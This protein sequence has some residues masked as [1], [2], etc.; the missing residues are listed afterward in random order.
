QSYLDGGREATVLTRQS[1]LSRL[2]YVNID[3][4]VVDR[5]DSGVPGDTFHNAGAVVI[6]RVLWPNK[7]IITQL[8]SDL[9]LR[10]FGQEGSSLGIGHFAE[11]YWNFGWWGIA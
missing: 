4:F 10:V 11:A 1:G 9:N 6:P 8:G 5:Y 3:A 7:P 2:S